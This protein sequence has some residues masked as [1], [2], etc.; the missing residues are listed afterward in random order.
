MREANCI[1]FPP[2]SAPLGTLFL[3]HKYMILI[4]FHVLYSVPV[5]LHS[6][7]LVNIFLLKA[8][9]SSLTRILLQYCCFPRTNSVAFT[10]LC[11]LWSLVSSTSIPLVWMLDFFFNWLEGGLCARTTHVKIHSLSCEIMYS[12]LSY[13]CLCFTPV[14]L[15]ANLIDLIV[16]AFLHRFLVRCTALRQCEFTFYAPVFSA[17]F[18]TASIYILQQNWWTR[19]ATDQNILLALPLT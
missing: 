2:S 10:V 13:M 5:K 6:A 14:Q 11:D 17:P 19:E 3:M 16:R 1:L 7:P 18:F 12:W 9:L 4:L 8:I 15:I